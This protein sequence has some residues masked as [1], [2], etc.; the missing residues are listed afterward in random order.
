[1]QWAPSHSEDKG[2][3]ENCG[4]EGGTKKVSRE[5]EVK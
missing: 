2:K 4:R 3:W 5:K 1:M